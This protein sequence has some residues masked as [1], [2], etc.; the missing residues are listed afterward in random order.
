MDDRKSH[1]KVVFVSGNFY[2]LHPGHVR[3]LRFAAECGQ[4]LVVGVNNISLDKSFPPPRERADALRE[5]SFVDR[6][7]VL[8][9]GLAHFLNGLRPDVV[10]KGK[11]FETQNNPE[12]AILRTY[13]GRLL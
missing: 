12:E 13:G 3:L 2:A 7:V 11:E 4:S 1:K 10:V 8:E 6:V 9:K 5:L